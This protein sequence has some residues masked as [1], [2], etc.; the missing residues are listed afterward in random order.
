MN[1]LIAFLILCISFPSF[2]AIQVPGAVK[3]QIDPSDL[4]IDAYSAYKEIPG[5]ESK[6]REEFIQA[7]TGPQGP[8]GSGGGSNSGLAKQIKFASLGPGQSTSSYAYVDTDLA[9][10]ITPQSSSSKIA[11]RVDGYSSNTHSGVINRFTLFRRIGTGAWTELTPVNSLG[12]GGTRTVSSDY[13]DHF[14]F[15]FEDSPNTTDQVTYELYW[16]VTTGAGYLGQRPDGAVIKYPT[17]MTA[18]EY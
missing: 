6:T 18:T 17:T 12:L 16:K 14:G 11:V 9:L 13:C 15:T 2:A 1:R 4:I 3:I 10:S 5:N 7:I 8:A